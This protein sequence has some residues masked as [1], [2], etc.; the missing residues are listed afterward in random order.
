MKTQAKPH[1]FIFKGFSLIPYATLLLLFNLV[2][3]LS[4]KVTSDFNG[5]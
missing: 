5:G 2:T 1:I 3:E 4:H